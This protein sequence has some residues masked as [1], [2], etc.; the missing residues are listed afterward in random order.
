MAKWL[1]GLIV[2]LLL[3]VFALAV[4]ANSRGSKTL[5]TAGNGAST[6]ASDGTPTASA[7]E[8]VGAYPAPFPESK[9]MVPEGPPVNPILS[10]SVAVELAKEQF[11]RTSSPD[12]A[13]ARR[14]S[15]RSFEHWVTY[16]ALPAAQQTEVAADTPEEWGRTN[17][18]AP[19]WLV[20]LLGT[21]LTVGDVLSASF[22]LFSSD[23]STPADGGY[24]AWDANSGDM[25]EAGVLVTGAPHNYASILAIPTENIPIRR[26]TRA[27]H[28]PPVTPLPTDTLAP[29]KRA[30]VAALYT[31]QAIRFLTATPTP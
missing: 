22:P 25:I 21:G 28:P 6:A 2:A 23:D 3:V 11:P 10:E 24:Y 8:Q 5:T 4:V 1:F 13:V 31:E 9:S 17:P 20:A 27:T 12:S 26:A 15:R 14:I 29:E 30:T 18:D 19:V 7:S 16:T